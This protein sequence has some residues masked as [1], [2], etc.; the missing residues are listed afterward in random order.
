MR[1]VA[2]R[3]GAD[4]TVVEQEWGRAIEPESVLAAAGG[5]SF[6]LLCIVHAETS[7]GVLQ[8]LTPFRSVADEL[9]ALLMV[10]AVTSL[11]GVPVKTDE[12][13][14]DAIYSGTQKC[15]SCPPG[16][17]PVSFSP[18]AVEVLT[19]RSHAV[20]SWY[21]DLNMIARYWGEERVYHHTAP[22]NMIYALY[23]SVRLV[24][25]E[26][27]EAR[28][29]RHQRNSRALI[30]GLEALGMSMLV[31]ENERLPSL[32]AVII[33]DGADDAA[34]RGHLMAKHSLEIG[35]GLGPLKGQIWRIG[36]MGAS[37]TQQHVDLALKAL[38]EAL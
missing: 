33:P 34:V 8:D 18:R 15:L 37:S 13:G 9:G 25:D 22:I 3:C 20:Q 38:E 36:L 14:I 10:D 28:W 6:K 5:K 7:T 19:H 21:L 11:G 12:W 26:G 30:A 23:E 4:V 27:L 24:L 17:A 29:E 32:N 1:D 2:E 35:A 31:P 16:L